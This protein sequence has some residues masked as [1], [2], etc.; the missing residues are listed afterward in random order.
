MQ[1]IYPQ[2]YKEY[3]NY[4]AEKY[5]VDP[6][7]IYA[8][9]KAESNFNPEAHSKS[10]ARGLMQ[11]M[12]NTAIEVA[13]QIEVKEVQ[14][15]DLYTPQTNIQIGTCYFANLVK[16][17]HNIGIAL[18]AYNAGMGRVNNWIEKGIIKED[19]SDLE[20]IPYQETNMYVRKILNDYQIYQELYEKE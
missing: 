7:L 10:D 8:I 19:G 5:E 20:N 11:L 9:I 18:A 1:K 17:Y 4:Y 12:E 3:V 15:E 13:N 14:V 2:K 16:Q 6:L